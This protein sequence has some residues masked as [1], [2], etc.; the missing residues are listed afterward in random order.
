MELLERAA[1]LQTLAE[2]AGE[3][4]R[5]N[6]RLVLVSGESGMG[7]T[8]LL[9][10][11]Q[12]QLP[13]ARW[14]WGGCDGLL[15]PARSARC[16]TSARNSTGSSPTCAV[17]ERRGLP[18]RAVFRAG[19]ARR[20]PRQYRPG[21]NA[22]ARREPSARLGGEPAEAAGGAYSGLMEGH[23]EAAPVSGRGS[24][25]RRGP[26]LLREQRTR[27]LRHMHQRLAIPR[28]VLS[29]A[30]GRGSGDRRPEAGQTGHLAGQ[31]AQLALHARHHPGVPRGG[32]GMGA[33][34]PALRRR[35]GRGVVVRRRRA[36]ERVGR[37]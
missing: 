23:D 14:L 9:E 17:P 19:H 7:K 33:H 3:A 12:H 35:A 30:V 32:R 29:R 11:S 26:R 34:R 24:L 13:D 8:V 5:G 27:C 16:S 36:E 1:F 18:G 31:P 10:E 20:V 21:R 15:T 37:A 4:Q 6:G 28:A 2:Y 22:R 25:L